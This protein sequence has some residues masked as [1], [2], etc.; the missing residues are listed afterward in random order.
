MRSTRPGPTRAFSCA[1]LELPELRLTANTFPKPKQT[2]G[3]NTPAAVRS[4]P[5]SPNSLI[6]S[7]SSDGPIV[8]RAVAVV[9]TCASA[10]PL[11]RVVAT[12]QHG[13]VLLLIS[14]AP[15]SIQRDSLMFGASVPPSKS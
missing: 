2:P 8:S 7:V 15:E 12:L 10:T 3:G 13:G 11:V 5:A 6:P 1:W 9:F 4:M 14:Q